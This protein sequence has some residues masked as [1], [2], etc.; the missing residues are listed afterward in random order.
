MCEASKQQIRSMSFQILTHI[1]NDQL[2]VEA[3]HRRLREIGNVE[4][5]PSHLPLHPAKIPSFCSKATML[6]HK[7]QANN[8]QDGFT[9]PRVVS[10]S[11]NAPQSCKQK[12]KYPDSHLSKKSP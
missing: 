6:T 10:H 11:T 5:H 2:V 7:E 12:H 3:F 4:F 1:I 9:P 8:L